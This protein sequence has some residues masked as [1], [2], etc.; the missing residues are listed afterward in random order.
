MVSIGD[1]RELSAA[2][3]YNFVYLLPTLRGD[4]SQ[5]RWDTICTDANGSL[6]WRCWLL[7]LL[8]RNQ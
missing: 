5:R 6:Y 8:V 3:C 4:L 1:G 7:W 2:V